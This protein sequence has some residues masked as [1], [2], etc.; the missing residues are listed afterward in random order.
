MCRPN[1]PHGNHGT[2][3]GSSR[4]PHFPELSTTL[5][6]WLDPQPLHSWPVLQDSQ[7]VVALLYVYPGAHAVWMRNSKLNPTSIT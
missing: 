4:L 1:R 3:Q 7:V 6:T 5:Q 2:E